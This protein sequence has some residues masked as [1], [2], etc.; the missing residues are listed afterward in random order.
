MP[1]LLLIAL[2]FILQAAFAQNASAV[3]GVPCPQTGIET[4][5]T[6]AHAYDPG[7]LVHMTGSGYAA[8]CD[9]VVKVTRPDGSVVTGDGTF[10]PGS[11]TVTTD[12]FGNLTYDYQL[13]SVPAIEGTYEVDVLGMGDAVLA[14][15]SFV[16]AFGVG[17]L[18]LGSI[19]GDENYIYTAGNTIVSDSD[20][21]ASGNVNNQRYYKFFILDASNSVRNSPTCT[22][23]GGGGSLTYSYTVQTSD[24]VSNAAYYTFLL[25]QY[26]GTAAAALAQCTGDTDGLGADREKDSA[27]V[28]DVAKATAYTSAALTTTTTSYAAGASAFVVV[29]GMQ[30]GTND[31][32]NTWIKPSET[33]ATATCLNTNGG[34]RADSSANGTLPDPADSSAASPSNDALQYPPRPTPNA[35]Q[36][37]TWNFLS[38]Y[39]TA[40]TAACPA[41]ASG[42]QGGWQLKLQKDSKHFVT[43][44]PFSADTTAPT[45]TINQTPAGTAG[46]PTTASTITFTATF[47]ENVTGFTGSDVSF[48]GSTAGTGGTPTDLSAA[49]TG[50]PTVYNVAVTGMATRGN[51]IA[52]IPAGGAQ[53][54][55][56]NT[57]TASTSTDNTVV[58]DR[59]PA[60]TTP[61]FSP[62]AP[63]TNDLLTASTTTSD[64]DGDNISVEWTFWRVNRGGNTCWIQS[65]SSPSAPAGVRTATLDLSANYVPFSCSG[66]MINPLNPSKGDI[67]SVEATPNDGLFN[68]TM[69]SSSVTIANTTPTVTLSGGN[70]LSP[71]EGS[72]Y[73]YNYS[74]S[75][76]DGDTIA[77]VATS[78]GIGTKTNPLNTNTAGSFDCTFAD[79]PAST[80]VSAQATDTGFGAGAGNL[81]MQSISVQNVDPTVVLSGPANVNESQT[82]HTYSFDTSDPGT[83]SFTH[84]TPSCGASGVLVGPV[85]FSAATGDGSFDCRFADDD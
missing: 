21:E 81:A 83:D 16:D 40:T 43:L 6:D 37:D 72:T 53:D 15:T 62:A 78:C 58:W 36:D 23:N 18:H 61:G 50:G 38:N 80:T 17:K 48:T 73:I 20:I 51:V 55:A 56:A 10:T 34:D 33:A 3:T 75:D 42:N 74:I 14:H 45:V 12:F 22:S 24:P 26:V 32:S 54:A 7:S 46:D 29:T 47:S 49:V 66:A 1:A 77:S 82:L 31:F 67:V 28:F 13:Q 39:D 2:A 44:S 70:N 52:S 8:V 63:K 69:Q 35:G 57:N 71:N 60:A 9:V 64:P 41:F 85:T 84:G 79:G 19:A 27:E 59:V 11:D 68:G 4:V 65:S 5:A 76:A 25:R 30:P